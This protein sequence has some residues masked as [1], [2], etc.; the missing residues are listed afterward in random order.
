M[1][2]L[3]GL[4][5]AAQLRRAEWAV[6]DTA[7]HL[8]PPSS[9]TPLQKMHARLTR[10]RDAAIAAYRDAMD[11]RDGAR[12]TEVEPDGYDTCSWADS[13]GCAGEEVFPVVMLRE[14]AC[15]RCRALGE[16]DAEDVQPRSREEEGCM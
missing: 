9:R 11:E 3:S 4:W 2:E 5:T 16:C 10:E 13:R 7:I 1:D 14:G 8:L 15:P 12:E 6:I